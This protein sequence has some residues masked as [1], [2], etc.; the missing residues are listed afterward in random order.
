MEVIRIIGLYR[1]RKG[2]YREETI[3]LT[4][5]NAREYRSGRRAMRSCISEIIDI[6][7]IV[8]VLFAGSWCTE[9]S[10]GKLRRFAAKLSREYCRNPPDKTVR[11]TPKSLES[12]CW[13]LSAMRY[14]HERIRKTAL[15]RSPDSH[16]LKYGR[17]IS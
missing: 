1:G 12:V 10:S 8:Q 7:D 6:R 16:G 2:Q 15:A 14:G 9:I 5:T 3:S 17:R 13:V 4:Q 11:V